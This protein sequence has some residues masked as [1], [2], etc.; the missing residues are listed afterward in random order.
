MPRLIV[1][2]AG[3]ALVPASWGDH[4]ALFYALDADLQSLKAHAQEM[5]GPVTVGRRSIHRLSLGTH[6]VYAIKMG[7]GT[8]ETAASTQALLTKFRCDMAFSIGPAGALTDALATGTWHRVSHVVAWQRGTA[9][10]AGYVQGASAKWDMDWS[11]LSTTNLPGILQTTSTIVI[12]S[13]EMFIASNTE[14]N[15]LHA[16]T[17]AE[18]VDMNTF[19]LAVV[20]QDHGVPLIAWRVISDYADEAASQAFREFITNYDGEG[21]RML[22]ELILGLPPNPDAPESYPEIQKLL[23]K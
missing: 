20:C 18:A 8:V 3:L 10:V 13:G 21:G 7:S 9:G 17:H 16:L 4:L 1:F 22:A 11:R 14:R 5:G 15:R 2:L 23:T 6:T 12:A 19:G